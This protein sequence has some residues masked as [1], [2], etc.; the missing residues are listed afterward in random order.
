MIQVAAVKTTSASAEPI[1][2]QRLFMPVQLM[3]WS[4]AVICL[5]D[6]CHGP[7]LSSTICGSAAG[8]A[9]KRLFPLRVQ[10][11]E[12]VSPFQHLKGPDRRRALIDVLWWK[13]NAPE[14]AGVA[15][16]QGSSHRLQNRVVG[17]T[18]RVSERRF[19]IIGFEVGEVSQDFFV[20]HAFGQ[21]PKNVRNPNAHSANAGPPATLARLDRDT[22]E[23]FHAPK[24]H[25][26]TRSGNAR[27]DS[28]HVLTQPSPQTNQPNGT[29]PQLRAR[30]SSCKSRFRA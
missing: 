11:D 23:K 22:F 19:D 17:L 30:L 1:A 10:F 18:S 21:H 16:R 5:M 9:A 26:S 24:M 13:S 20:P 29:S 14:S 28:R 27:Q 8:S 6:S 3:P 25:G 2:I 15:R 7:N 4:R 12:P